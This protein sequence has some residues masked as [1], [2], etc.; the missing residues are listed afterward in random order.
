MNLKTRIIYR[1]KDLKPI[2]KCEYPLKDYAEMLSMDLKRIITDV[3][4]LAYTMNGNAS[5]EEW[6]SAEVMAFQKIKHKLLDKAG[7]IGRLPECIFDADE[8]GDSVSD[9]WNS[10]FDEEE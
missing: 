8:E 6:S 9:F 5:K 3:E 4:D 2:S 1:N 7:E 10:I